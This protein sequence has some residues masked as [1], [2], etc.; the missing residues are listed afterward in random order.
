M[1]NDK[2][3]RDLAIKVHFLDEPDFLYLSFTYMLLDR[4]N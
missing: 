4:S 1:R 2:N 3:L